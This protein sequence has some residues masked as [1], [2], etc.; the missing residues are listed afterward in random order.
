MA[1][2]HNAPGQAVGAAPQD[3]QVPL[4]IL[5]QSQRVSTEV[6]ELPEQGERGQMTHVAEFRQPLRR[7]ARA[8][9][10]GHHRAPVEGHPERSELA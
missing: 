7:V 4:Q 8:Q 2:A 1:K 5:E 6:S 9:A 10:P 3:Q